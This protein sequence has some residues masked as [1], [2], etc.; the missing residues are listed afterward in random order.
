MGYG[1]RDESSDEARRW[2]RIGLRASAVLVAIIAAGM[3]GCPQYDVWRQGLVGQAELRRAE[4]N[5]KIAVQEAEAKREASHLLAEAEVERAKGVAAAN[6]IIGDSLKG[7]E[8]YLRYLWVQG[9][10][11]SAGHTVYVA[12]EAGMP[13]MEAGRFAVPAHTQPTKE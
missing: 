8:A 4:Q 3:A 11:T 7:N 12:T 6:Q 13:I 2:M 10:Q 1:Q 9:M 5:R